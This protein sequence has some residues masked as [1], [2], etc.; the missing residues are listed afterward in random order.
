MSKIAFMFPGQGAQKAGMGKD[1]Y[2]QSE[3]ARKVIDKATELLD[4]DMKALCF[5]ENDKL[6]Q[7]EYTQAALV[8]VCLA[9]EH[10]LRERGLKA[11][12]TAG[13]SLGEYCAIASAGGMSTEDAITTV[14]KRGILMQNAVPGGKGTMAAVLG[15]KGEDIEKVVDSIDG[16]TIANYNCPGQIVITGWKES[17]EKA[18]EELKA[19]GAKRVMP[20]NVSGPFH[21]PMLEEAGRELGQVL[22]GVQLS[23]LEIPYVTNVTAEYVTDISETKALL[24]TQVAS[25]VRWQQ[26]VE[27]MIADGVDTFVEIGPGRTLAGFMR[28]I[29]RDV[30][31]YNVGTWEDVD[32]VVSELC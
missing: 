12:V 1:F 26:S 22:A 6:D 23:K 3:T 20:L 31:V 4:I 24:A 10:V 8:T 7:T 2:E 17:V 32:K 18:S 19:A 27:N 11:D 9:M 14:R 28:K 30:K 21:S 13:L 25:S 29:S 15:M 16:V 5:E